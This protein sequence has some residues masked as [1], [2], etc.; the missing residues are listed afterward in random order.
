M[1]NI[2]EKVKPKEQKMVNKM[3]VEIFRASVHD[4]SYIAKI[5][6]LLDLRILSEESIIYDLNNKNCYYYIAKVNDEC[7]G[8]IAS[9]FMVDHFDILSIVVNKE[10]RQN[11]IAS[12][13]LNTLFNKT[14]ELKV[15]DVFLEV[16]LSNITAIKFYEKNGFNKISIR[17][18]YYKNPTEDAYILKKE[19]V[20]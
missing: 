17:K 12:K 5:E 16:R 1:L 13:L 8:Y 19:L 18:S 10:Y 14:L 9:C 7:V 4:A 15:R 2:I 20:N 3:D 11:G 6:N